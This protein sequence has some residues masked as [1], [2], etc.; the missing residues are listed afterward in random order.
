MIPKALIDRLYEAASI[1]RWN[2]HVRPMDFTELD[3][4]AHKAFIAWLLARLEEQ[5][6]EEPVDLALLA[7]GSVFGLLERAVLTD[8]KA[9]VFHVLKARAG[10]AINGYL[11]DVLCA[12][13]EPV[14]G[15]L[16]ERFA[17]WL[18]DPHYA[19]REKSMLRA[20]HYLA[21][22]W[23]FAI[24]HHT[25][26]FLHGVE[27]TRRT[28]DAEIAQHRD[29]VGV[30]RLEGDGAERG[31][32][33]LVGQLR[34]QLRWAGTPRIP[35]TSVL[36]HSFIVSALAWLATVDREEEDAL[37]GWNW[38]GGLFHDLPEALT[39]DIVAPVKHSIP[40]V[41]EAVT[42]LEALYVR[43]HLLPLLPESL[44][45]E[46]LHL[47]EDPFAD[48][49]IVE[50]QC[51]SGLTRETLRDPAVD[52]PIEGT[53]LKACDRFA[54]YVEAATSIRHGVSSRHLESG[55]ASLLE[56]FRDV[57]VADVPFGTYTEYYT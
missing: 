11:R 25:A 44:H 34:F 22:R 40:G 45:A 51:L 10:E 5:A 15:G 37:R 3:K 41:G 18:A 52:A 31:F 27:E 19:A 48:R 8:I 12:E 17:R 36:G 14:A 7:E 38:L 47:V 33:D 28:I 35:Q 42:R 50:G 23:E 56:R 54:A 57:V 2:D 26:P 16:E 6:G 29:F 49:A 43:D 4:Q 9:P 32:V 53:M 39:R 46:L 1:Q 30:R 21:T 55:V 24:V 13:L 20:A